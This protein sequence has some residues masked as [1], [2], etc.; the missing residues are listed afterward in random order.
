MKKI[1]FILAVV[2][3]FSLAFFLYASA[4]KTE[5]PPS[6]LWSFQSVDTMKFSR[7]V[8]RE[9]LNDSTFDK[10]IASQ[11]RAIAATGA[12]HVGIATP[13]DEEFLPI[14]NRW[15]GVARQQGLKIWYRG[16]W[17][18]WEGWF[19]YPKINRQTHIQKTQA[20]ILNH[21]ELFKDGDIFS[22]CPECENG[23]PGDPRLNGD[24]AGHRQFLINEHNVAKKAFKQIGKDI[25]VNYNSMNGD[26]AR[27]IM[28]KETT[29]ALGGV[30]V[31]DH[32]VRTPNILAADIEAIAK[33]SGGKVVLGEF[34]VPILDINGPMTED[35][36][37]EWIAE[38]MK[39]LVTIEELEGLNYW[40]NVGGSTA[41]FN[42][43]GSP[44]KVV[45]TLTSFF[46]P[47][48]VEVRVLDP[49]GGK[50]N[51][52]TVHTLNRTYQSSKNTVQVPM[53]ENEQDFSVT[54]NG[55]KSTPSQLKKSE[56]ATTVV[57]QP[58]KENMVYKIK[59]YLHALLNL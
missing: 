32:Y 50:I 52:A 46:D 23:G 41:L 42:E 55:Y 29:K 57:L 39:K 56:M 17:S 8:S 31:I 43:D 27:L 59:K 28:D 2:S 11:I 6:P 30:V 15:V 24:A 21:P 22:P 19:E 38:A 25:N 20:F 3:F 7:D 54:A 14:L 45:S 35:E 12:T 16:N 51:G 53:V 10:T 34:G 9:K 13:Y 40:V 5:A 58:V 37:S 4:R 44:R 33:M 47:Q 36:Q 1:F 18:G 48:L 26:V 49:L